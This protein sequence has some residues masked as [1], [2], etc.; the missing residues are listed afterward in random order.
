MDATR[1]DHTKWSKSEKDKYDIYMQDLK[2]DI[3]EL[4]YK[5]DI[6]QKTQKTNLW[7]PRESGGAEI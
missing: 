7:L 6:D 5:T 4:I 2:N 3:N 1:D